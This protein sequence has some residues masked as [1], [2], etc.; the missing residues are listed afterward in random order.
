MSLPSLTQRGYGAVRARE[1]DKIGIQWRPALFSLDARELDHLR[2]LFG[3]I[4]DD[5][6]ECRRRAPKHCAAQLDDPGFDFG[7]SEAGIELL[8]QHIDD[9]GRG[10]PG[11]ANA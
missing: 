7:I 9:F 6:P 2:P 8:V 11:G 3:G 10:G 1:T 4:R 5:R